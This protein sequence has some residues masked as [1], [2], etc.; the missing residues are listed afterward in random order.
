MTEIYLHIYLRARQRDV[1]RRGEPVLRAGEQIH[2]PH[3]SAVHA[4]VTV[5]IARGT[6]CF[7]IIRTLETMHD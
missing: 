5:T 7:Q 2:L 1:L 3:P 6:V 4:T